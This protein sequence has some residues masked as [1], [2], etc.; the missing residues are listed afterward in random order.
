MYKPVSGSGG[1]ASADSFGSKDG[2]VEDL[3]FDRIGKHSAS[4]MYMAEQ[5]PVKHP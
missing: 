3:V 4:S 1:E 5:R 2:T